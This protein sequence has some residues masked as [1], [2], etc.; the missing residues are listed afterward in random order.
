[1]ARGQSG[2]AR[3][4]AASAW[5]RRPGRHADVVAD[6]VETSAEPVEKRVSWAELFFDLVFVFAVTRSR[7]SSRPI[8]PGPARCAPWSSSCPSTGRGWASRS[9][10]TWGHVDPGLRIGMFAVALA[11]LFMAL[12]VPDGTATARSSSRSRTGPPGWCW[13]SSGVAHD[14][15][16]VQ[17]VHGQHDHHRPDP[18]RRRPHRRLGSRSPSGGWPPLIDLSTRPSCAVGCEACTS[19]PP[20]WPSA[21]GS[22]C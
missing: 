10:P 3:L 8:T 7:P 5:P 6:A 22:S 15:W 14:G 16:R 19:T 1:V 20:T 4:Q 11:G 18:G 9:R 17:P 21:S 13:G 2:I 12:A